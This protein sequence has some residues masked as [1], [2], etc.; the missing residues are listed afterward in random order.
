MYFRTDY[1]SEDITVLRYQLKSENIYLAG[2]MRRCPWGFPQ[3][4]LL[5]PVLKEAGKS[6]HVINFIAFSTPLWLTCPF[7]NDK[8]H[9]LEDV[10]CVKKI[11][12]LIQS[13]EELLEAMKKAHV[14]YALMRRKLYY[15]F[16]SDVDTIEEHQS[17]MTSG[18]GGIRA[19]NTIKCLHLHF[20]HYSVYAANYAG[21]ITSFMLGE[22]THCGEGR[23]RNVIVKE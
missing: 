18:I 10:G 13:D 6:E 2:V 5:S 7:L 15:Q 9:K 11:E 12:G 20:A 19:W 23:C 14:H 8:I 4:V 21:R 22:E 1:S 17:L 16:I 3:T